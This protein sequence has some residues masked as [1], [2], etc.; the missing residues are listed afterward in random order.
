MTE[1]DYTQLVQM[2]KDYKDKGLEILAYPC[3]QFGSQEPESAEW[4]LD[5]VKKYDVEFPMME[6]IQVFGKRQHPLYKWLR[7]ESELKG[8]DMTW[9]FEKFLINSDGHIV[10]YFMTSTDPDGCRAEIDKL[11]A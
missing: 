3:D 10:K 5:F 2:Y 9:N 6:K 4:I 1:R 8:A 7:D 11:V